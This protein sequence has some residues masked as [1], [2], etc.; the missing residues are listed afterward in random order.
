MEIGSCSLIFS[1]YNFAAE[2][3]AVRGLSGAAGESL[4][5]ALITKG[6]GDIIAV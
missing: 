1:A 4:Q 5:K 2:L 6:S 3:D